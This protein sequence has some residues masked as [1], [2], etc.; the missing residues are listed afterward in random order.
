MVVI[1][2]SVGAFA[3]E[4]WPFPLRTWYSLHVAQKKIYWHH[5]GERFIK[6]SIFA[7]AETRDIYAHRLRIVA[8][9]CVNNP[10]ELSREVSLNH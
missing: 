2:N 9:Q 5:A 3:S 10:I 1:D 6:Q 8:G 4:A 7:S